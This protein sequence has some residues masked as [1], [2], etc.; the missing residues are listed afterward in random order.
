MRILLATAVAIA[1]LMVATGSQA[2]IVISNARTTPIQTS[3]ATGTAADNIRIASGGSVAM[4]GCL[5]G[6]AVARTS[7]PVRIAVA[8]DL[9][10]GG[11]SGRRI[12]TRSGLML[13]GTGGQHQQGWNQKKRF[14]RAGSVP[15]ATVSVANSP[16]ASAQCMAARISSSISTR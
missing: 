2:E 12:G 11:R 10:R 9:R 4:L 16:A 6:H 13:V 8:T 1:P 3:N 5:A 7:H 15:K 14:H